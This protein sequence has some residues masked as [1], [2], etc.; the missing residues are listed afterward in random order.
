MVS[1]HWAWAF[2]VTSSVNLY[3]LGGASLCHMTSG[4]GFRESGT[5]TCSECGAPVTSLSG[6]MTCIACGESRCEGILQ[7]LL[8]DGME[9]SQ[10]VQKP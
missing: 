5:L 1:K 10:D 8:A 3:H 7:T 6:C 4:E 9:F 2:S